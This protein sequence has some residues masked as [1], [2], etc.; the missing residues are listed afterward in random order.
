MNIRP[1]SFSII[2]FILLASYG[3]IAGKERP[4]DVVY[5][6]CPESL[7]ELKLSFAY[8][9]NGADERVELAYYR[10]WQA[11]SGLSGV[12]HGYDFGPSCVY[13]DGMPVDSPNRS[14]FGGCTYITSD[15]KG[16]IIT[17]DYYWSRKGVKGTLKKE[18][19]IPFMKK[20][21][22]E[23]GDLKYRAVWSNI[24]PQ[25]NKQATSDRGR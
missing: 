14:Y 12:S 6:R 11:T 16:V 21:T 20:V 18:I 10:K 4:F 2:I 13:G 17:L 8:S 5:Q 3:N 7:A 9:I 24:Q 25:H 1:F 15:G 19:P 22:A 23:N